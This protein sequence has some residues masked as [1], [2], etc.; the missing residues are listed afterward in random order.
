M[1]GVAKKASRLREVLKTFM[2]STPIPTRIKTLVRTE[3]E[4]WDGVNQIVSQEKIELV[5][6]HWNTTQIDREFPENLE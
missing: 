2:E 3:G 4:L 5:V 6:A 1:S